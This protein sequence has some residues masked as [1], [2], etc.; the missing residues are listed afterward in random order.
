MAAASFGFSLLATDFAA[1]WAV[2]G[3]AANAA[4]VSISDAA[5]AIMIVFIDWFL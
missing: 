4:D 2:A 3:I 1:V 5:A